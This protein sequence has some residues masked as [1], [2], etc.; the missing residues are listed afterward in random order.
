VRPIIQESD[1][2]EIGKKN[3]AACAILNCI[4]TKKP[5][6]K[7]VTEKGFFFA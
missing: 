1:K 3:G 5:F 2:K 6:S 7:T 4:N